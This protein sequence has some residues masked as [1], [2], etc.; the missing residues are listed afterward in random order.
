MR[1]VLAE[2]VV[3]GIAYFVV[4]ALDGTTRDKTVAS[5]VTLP[6]CKRRRVCVWFVL[7]RAFLCF[8]GFNQV[9]RLHVSLLLLFVVYYILITLVSSMWRLSAE[10]KTKQ[11]LQLNLFTSTNNITTK[12]YC[13]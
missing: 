2:Y 4:L 12:A 7:E 3:M 6:S 8:G 10:A 13:F 5:V 11:Y 9:S 1:T